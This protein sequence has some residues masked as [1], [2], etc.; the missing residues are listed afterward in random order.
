MTNGCFSKNN[1]PWSFY[2]LQHIGIIEHSYNL[3]KTCTDASQ[4]IYK[5]RN[6]KG[7]ITGPLIGG[8]V[9]CDILN[10]SW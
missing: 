10:I 6:I 8:I 5:S 7:K 4:I 9:K 1:K 2:E 3:H